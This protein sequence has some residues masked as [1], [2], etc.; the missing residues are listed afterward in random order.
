MFCRQCGAQLSD[1]ERFCHRCGLEQTQPPVQRVGYSDRI[2]DPAFA[3]YLKNTNRWA[4]I[5]ASIL[6]V[7][8]FVG[9]TI[10]G[11]SGGEMENPEAMYIGLGIGGM[12]LLIALMTVISRK[13]SKTWD[14][15]VVNKTIEHKQRRKDYGDHDYYWVKYIEYAVE[16]QPDQGKLYRISAEDDDTQYNYYRIGD[17]VRHHGSLNSLEK[18]DKTGDRIIFCNACA[19]LNDIRDDVCFRCKCPLLK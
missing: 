2:Q 9:F 5:F 1:Q 15:T 4:A 12:F 18:Y 14:G 8:A 16:I 6:A 19:S 13:R 7:A 10:Y 3:R 11:E 17:R